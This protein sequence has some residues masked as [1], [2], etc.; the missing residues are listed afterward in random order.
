MRFLTLTLFLALGTA[1]PASDL[2]RVEADMKQQAD[3]K[4]EEPQTQCVTCLRPV[5]I[6]V[7][8][9]QDFPLTCVPSANSQPSVTHLLENWAT[10]SAKLPRASETARMYWAYNQPQ[11]SG[12][13]LAML[14]DLQGPVSVESLR[15]Q[16]TWTVKKEQKGDASTII[17]SAVPCDPLEQLF[18]SNISLHFA[19]NSALP[20]AIRMVRPANSAGDQ[21]EESTLISFKERRNKTF[22]SQIVPASYAANESLQRTASLD[23]YA[24]ETTGVIQQTTFKLPPMPV[25]D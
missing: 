7:T 23:E 18:V 10:A 21:A 16:F 4:T 15:S 2:P 20:Q 1:A 22:A 6:D 25:R 14:L 11:L 24:P 5:A 8:L 13:E 3:T 9:E 12:H 19:E 17:L